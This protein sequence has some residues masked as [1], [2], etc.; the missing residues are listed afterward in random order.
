MSPNDSNT[1]FS[2]RQQQ[3]L[4]VGLVLLAAAVAGGFHDW[5]QFFRSYL[6]SFVFWT[7]VSLGCMAILMI[8]HLVTG[9][10]GFALRRLLESGAKTVA[11]MAALAVPLML[12]LSK[13]Y[14]WANPAAA[15]ADPMPPFK[16]VY[17]SMPF[18]LGRTVIYFAAWLL[19]AYLLTKWSAEQD[20]TGDPATRQR[21]AR[22]SAGGLLIYGLTLTYASVDW[23]MSLEP[24][25][26][27]TIYGM[28][29]IVTGMLA[30][31]SLVTVCI[32]LLADREPFAGIIKPQLLNDFGNL[33]LMLT[34][35]WAYL[36]F[37]QY[38]IIWAGNLQDEIPWYIKR[39][40]GHWAWVALGLIVFHFAVPFVLLLLRFVKRRRQMLGLV[41]A[42][43][44]VMSMV[45][46]FWLIVPSF[47]P[48]AP[49]F[50]WLD[51]ALLLGVGGVWVSLFLSQ[52]KRRPL[53]ALRD[54]R[55]LDM[56]KAAEEGAHGG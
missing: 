27:S 10:W 5:T 41:A 18:Y 14:S 31:M 49:Q 1:V 12:N 23:V 17:L 6:L 55:W 37:S 26:F 3:A 45:D 21:L 33:L 16:R 48:H 20:T 34:M 4:V 24:K 53:M 56:Q 7:G 8:H 46:I 42:G 13:L 19:L 47:Q 22:L 44:F 25:W 52:L 39:A 28:V 2:R 9:K 30:A 29:F 38:L 50:H 32:V 11:L 51:Y 35:L 43:L 54:P 40:T 36:S 15:A